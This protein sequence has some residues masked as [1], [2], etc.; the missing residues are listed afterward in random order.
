MF[1]NAFVSA[2]VYDRAT[3]RHPCWPS[4]RPFTSRVRPEGPGA[5]S[6]IHRDP[7]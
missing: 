7:W 3:A 1:L 5:F 2:S 6:T 4:S